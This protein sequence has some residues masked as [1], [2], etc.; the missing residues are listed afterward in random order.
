MPRHGDFQTIN[1][2]ATQLRRSG[3]VE[4][5]K[6]GN[7]NSLGWLVS[8]G[9][10]DWWQAT[11]VAE[12]PGDL[13]SITLHEMGH[14]LFAHTFY[15]NWPQSTSANILTS[16][17]IVGYHGNGIPVAV[18]VA[19]TNVIDRLSLKAAFGYNYSLS[20]SQTPYGRWVWSRSW[21]C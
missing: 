14:A 4:I 12:V 20:P 11:G 13:Y 18:D 5:E 3:A 19:H 2:G 7:Y 15:P 6:K 10:S 8:T 16:P 17:K 21:T 1:G 9:D